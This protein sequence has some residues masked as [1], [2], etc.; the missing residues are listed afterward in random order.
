[1]ITTMS[2]SNY[3]MENQTLDTEYEDDIM[4]AG[5]NPDVDFLCE[6]QLVIED[7]WQT[8]NPVILAALDSL[9]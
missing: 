7:D 9:D 1:M 4:Y 8:P 3:E 6:Q 5:W 2:M